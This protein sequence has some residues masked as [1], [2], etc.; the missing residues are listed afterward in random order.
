MAATVF[1]HERLHAHQEAVRFVA[2]VARTKLAPGEAGAGKDIL[3]GVV[4][5]VAGRIARFSDRGSEEGIEYQSTAE[6]N[7][8]D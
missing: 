5:L 4:S 6:E 2:W 8:N 7:E 1:D 3:L